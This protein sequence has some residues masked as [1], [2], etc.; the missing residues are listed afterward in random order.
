[1]KLKFFWK[2]RQTSISVAV[3]KLIFEGILK[4]EFSGARKYCENPP[5]NWLI[6]KVILVYLFIYL[7]IYLNL[8]LN[9]NL[10]EKPFRTLWI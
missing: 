9:L 1:M 8:N 4:I 10:K 3:N 5:G 2:W 6:P 7:F